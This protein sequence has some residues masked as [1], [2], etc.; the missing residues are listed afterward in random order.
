MGGKVGTVELTKLLASSF[1]SHGD[2]T[3]NFPIGLLHT[4]PGPRR[5]KSMTDFD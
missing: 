4:V 2:T 3:W 1:I 5:I